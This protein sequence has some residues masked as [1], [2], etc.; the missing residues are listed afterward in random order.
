MAYLRLPDT[1]SVP[2]KIQNPN[3]MA[4]LYCAE[5]IHIAQTWIWMPIWTE[6]SNWYSTLFW[7][8]YSYPDRDLSPA[9]VM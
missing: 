4:T 7:D 5:H 8:R 9:P 1:D 3:M 6:I 2:I